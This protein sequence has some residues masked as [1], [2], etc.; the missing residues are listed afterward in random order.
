MINFEKKDFAFLVHFE[1]AQH[2]LQDGAYSFPVNSLTLIIDESDM[3]TFRKASN[4]DVVFSQRIDQIQFDGASVD[5]DSIYAKFAET[6]TAALG[7]DANDFYTKAEIDNAE[8]ATSAALNDLNNRKAD[9]DMYYTKSEIDTIISGIL[10][11]I[12]GN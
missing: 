7:A 5:K 2:Y 6:C 1:D 3:A 12:N 8:Q 4:N 9:K 10:S 11:Q